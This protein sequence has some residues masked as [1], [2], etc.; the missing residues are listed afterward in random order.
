MIGWVCG[1]IGSSMPSLIAAVARPPDA[2][3]P[4]VLD[5]DVRL[6]RAD[7]RVEDERAGDDDV[8][9]GRTRPALGRSAVGA[10][11]RSPRSV[12]RRAPGGPRRRGPTGRCRPRRTRSPVRRAVACEAS[13][14]ERRVIR[15]PPR[16]PASPPN[17]TSR[18]VR[19]S[20]GAQRSVP[21]RE[22]EAEPASGV[23]IEDQPGV[24]ALERVVGRHPDRRAATR[25]GRSARS[26]PEAH[27]RS[28]PAASGQ[29][30]GAG[31]VARRRLP[32]PPQRIEHDHEPRAVT[33]QDLQ[34]D[35]LDQ[36]RGP[37]A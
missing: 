20:P 33:Q 25:C 24:H 3:D 17:R 27:R 37:P 23:A 30:H 18:T 2:D 9:L 26:N 16:P 21:G 19:V 5:A 22:V 29:P 34:P 4:P 6:D 32:G 11:S 14:G 13:A 7:E 28:E 1:P 35:L 15:S 10:S 8:E 31:P 12:R 36:A